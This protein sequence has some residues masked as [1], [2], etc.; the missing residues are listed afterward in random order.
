M[1]RYRVVIFD[2]LNHLVKVVNEL[3]ESGDWKP[4]G[5]ICCVMV[6]L[7]SSF[8]QAMVRA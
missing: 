6:G 8:I 5:G 7:K 4:Q 2:D 1:R 3:I